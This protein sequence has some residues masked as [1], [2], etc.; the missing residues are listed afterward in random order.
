VVI[1]TSG[2]RL[3]LEL[4]EDQPDT[5]AVDTETDGRW[6]GEATLLGVSLAWRAPD[7]HIKARYTPDCRIVPLLGQM[8]AEG[9][10]PR[11][12]AHN[13]KFDGWL[14]GR[15]GWNIWA[16]WT[17]CTMVQ[18]YVLRRGQV[19]GGLGLKELLPAD[20]KFHISSLAV[21]GHPTQ[22]DLVTLGHYGAQ[23]SAA[24]LRLF[25]EYERRL[26]QEP[27][28]RWVYENLDRPA[29]EVTQV[30]EAT[31]FCLDLEAIDQARTVAEE[32]KERALDTLVGAGLDNPN[33]PSQVTTLLYNNLGLPILER[34]NAGNP[35]ADSKTLKFLLGEDLAPEA[36]GVV[37]DLLLYREADKL[38]GTYL[39]KLPNLVRPETGRVHTHFNHAFVETGRF[40]SSD[41]INFQNIPA[42]TK[43]GQAVRKAFVPPPG[44][45]LIKA[46]W[47]QL[48]LRI[49]AAF[50]RDPTLVGAFER[51]ED[52]HTAVTSVL[53]GIPQDQVTKDQRTRGKNLNFGIVYGMG[54]RSLAT[55]LVISLEEAKDLLRDY[56]NK[57]PRVAAWISWAQEEAKRTGFAETWFGR[58]NY[59]PDL[60]DSRAW[61]RHKAERESVNQRIQGTGGDLMRLLMRAAYDK[62]VRP[63]YAEIPAQAH[64]ELVLFVDWSIANEVAQII[65]DLGENIADLGVHLVMEVRVGHNWVEV[66]EMEDQDAALPIPA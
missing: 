28:L 36:R 24:A 33:S 7:G 21:L 6:E 19:V 5:L 52:V 56:W 9:Y 15:Y 54:Y 59:Y 51:A 60:R 13:A 41:P 55:N 35:S 11:L 46:D 44:K 34:T 63:G 18:A 8:K 66:E 4:L 32:Q 50:S 2:V 30:M 16:H 40:S 27:K 29:I 57:L 58:R 38:L 10:C 62:L 65:K 64:D 20:T 1:A 22:L 31:G 14:L 49:L 26:D 48:E 45:A 12:I 47:S 61:V 43:L 37:E 3:L 39:E 23:D 42:R 17:D 25:E 53:F